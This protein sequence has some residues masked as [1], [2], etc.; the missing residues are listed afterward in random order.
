MKYRGDL[1]LNSVSFILA[2]LSISIFLTNI[3]SYEYIVRF[4]GLPSSNRAVVLDP[5]NKRF[6]NI[7]GYQTSINAIIEYLRLANYTVE[8]YKDSDVSLDL[9][10]D[11]CSGNY[12]VVYLN[13]HGYVDKNGH[14]YV[15][16]GELVSEES[17][18]D[19]KGVLHLPLEEDMNEIYVAVLPEFIRYYGGM[20]GKPLVF[21][22]ACFSAYN[23]TMASAFIDVGA[24]CYIGWSGSVGVAIGAKIDA[25]FF[26]YLA[27]GDTIFVALFKSG[28][29]PITTS[30]LVA[31]GDPY[32][33]L[34][35]IGNRGSL[36]MIG[37]TTFFLISSILLMVL[38]FKKPRYVY[39]YLHRVI[40]WLASL[41]HIT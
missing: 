27:R 31:Y 10:R 9:W 35:D 28:T 5:F 2:L 6:K 4:S 7:D 40:R 13:T 30:R 19:D 29:D 1:G 21:I 14:V 38:S 37:S 34:V 23:P 36:Y 33:A 11:I 16:L 17:I 32:M 15:Y 41:L 22:D 18:P 39:E 3:V 26:G 20:T 24:G 12:G 25:E 8:Y